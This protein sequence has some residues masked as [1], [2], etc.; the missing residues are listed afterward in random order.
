MDLSQLELFKATVAHENSGKFLYYL[1]FAEST[2]DKVRR[3]LKL[4]DNMDLT[5]YFKIPKAVEI[6]LSCSVNR[7]ESD[8]SEYYED[9]DIPEKAYYDELGVLRLP[10]ST[11][12]FTHRISPLRKAKSLSEIEKYPYPTPEIIESSDMGRRVEKA[13]QSGKH[14]S[15][16]IGQIYE[17]SWQIRGYE[18]F[19]MDMAADKEICSY[20]LDKFTDIS[21][22]KAIAAAKAGVD[23]ITSG[24]D[25]ANQSTLMFSI[26]QWREIIK[27]RW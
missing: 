4:D 21:T 27:P 7:P 5:E 22:K 6:S 19:L 23:M 3:E 25:V 12:H 8:L 10:G 24:D 15:S 2:A 26:E 20:I 11:Y 16:F 14:T 9:I 17:Y 18:E 13:H 1:N